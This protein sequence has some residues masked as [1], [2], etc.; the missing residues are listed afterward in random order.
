MYSEKV[1]C[2][3]EKLAE[4]IG[5]SDTVLTAQLINEN[6]DVCDRAMECVL[7]LKQFKEKKAY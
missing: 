7:Q 6:E 1:E 4:A 3:T 2:Q 5:D